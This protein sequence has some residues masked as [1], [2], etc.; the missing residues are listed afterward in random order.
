MSSI[1][2]INAITL[3]LL[4]PGCLLLIAIL[5][6]AIIKRRPGLGRGL[7]ALSFTALYALST[8]YV[9]N[10]LLQALEP[11]PRDPLARRDGQAI[12]VLG[13]GRDF[14]APEYGADTVGAETLVRLRYAARLY[15]ATGKPVLVSG[16]AP[17][18]SPT[19]EA[20]TMKAVLEREFQVPVTW[21]EGRS[22][23]T[24]ENARLSAQILDGAGIRRV[25][26]VTHAWHMPRA[27]LAFEHAGLA[28]IPAPTRFATA[29]RLGAKDFLPKARALLDSS[30]FFHELIG[31]GW[32]QLK[33]LFARWT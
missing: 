6:L 7:I 9:A 14:A 26:L 13:G 29:Y 5:G 23:N 17:E 15:R 19:D 8:Q 3:L 16:G 11:V 10:H 12:V 32:Y 21:R 31:I 24:L 33:F 25:Y 28:V 2:L 18:G 30:R 22:N 4:P 20:S 1:E 27:V